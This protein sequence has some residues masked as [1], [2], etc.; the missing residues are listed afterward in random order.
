MYV[1]HIRLLV[2]YKY[3]KNTNTNILFYLLKKNR[4]DGKLF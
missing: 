2:S 3:N 4:R 1:A